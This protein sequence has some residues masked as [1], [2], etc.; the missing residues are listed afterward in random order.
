[1]RF[2]FFGL[3]G[4]FSPLGFTGPV[5]E[6]SDKDRLELATSFQQLDSDII[7]FDLSGLEN[8]SDDIF[9]PTNANLDFEYLSSRPIAYF[10]GLSSDPPLLESQLTLFE[11]SGPDAY[12]DISFSNLA[13]YEDGSYDTSFAGSLVT[14]VAA[15]APKA[16]SC[17]SLPLGPSKIAF[18]LLCCETPC[19]QDQSWRRS[20]DH[21][22]SI[23]LASTFDSVLLI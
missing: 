23:S 7:D 18:Q 6:A 16:P 19:T 17:S 10:D 8:Y 22:I 11:N 13:N 1:M 9:S 4:M 12:P 3:L 14:N 20:C 2:L 15:V 5:L 21:C